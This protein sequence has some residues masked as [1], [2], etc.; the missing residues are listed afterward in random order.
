MKKKIA[1][2]ILIVFSVVLIISGINILIWYKDNQT[3][4]KLL[5][6]INNDI[7]V[8]TYEVDLPENNDITLKA[9]KLSFY[10]ADIS[11]IKN[12]IGYL[13]V[14]NTN[15][16]YPFT[17]GKD[18]EYYLK[19]SIDGKKNRAGWIFMDYR[20][21]ID[22]Q[23]VIIYGHNMKNKSMFGSLRDTLN[24]EWM[25]KEE[26]QIIRIST[27]DKNYIYKLFSVYT[28]KKGTDY[29]QVEFKDNKEFINFVNKMQKRSQFK[30]DT[31]VEEKDKV[32][33]LST[34][35]RSTKNLVFHA[36]LIA[37]QQKTS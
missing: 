3:S 4:N 30:F 24:N 5:N 33:T 8:N 13:I 22:D 7:V 35:H 1:L 9:D 11:K 21:K 6:N 29:L 31:K 37:T 14:N 10:N 20:N 25:S 36:K 34:C 17:Q 15:V 2:G 18:N 23:H 26:N 12:S 16:S 32:L 19:H 28:Q 27:N